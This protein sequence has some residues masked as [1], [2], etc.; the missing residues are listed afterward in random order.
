MKALHY[1]LGIFLLAFSVEMALAEREPLTKD[2]LQQRLSAF[3]E[4]YKAVGPIA[5]MI[6]HDLAFPRSASEYRIMNGFGI[7]WITA[8]SQESTELPLQNMW[9]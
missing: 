9:I 3:A 6:N 1:L 5:R 8:H 2:G 7:I 4:Q